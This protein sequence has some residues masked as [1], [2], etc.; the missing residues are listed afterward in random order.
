MTFKYP[1]RMM[2]FLGSFALSLA[3]CLSV[4]AMYIHNKSDMEYA[5]ME[6]VVLVNAN[7]VNNVITKLLYKTQILAALVVQS[8]G[9]INEFERVAATIL[10]DPAI[11]NVLIAPDGIVSAVYPLEG[12]EQVLGLNFFEPGHGNVEAIEARDSGELVLGGPFDLVQGGQALV[13]RLPVY[14]K[15][16]TNTPSFWGV[17]SVTL[18]YPEA[19]SGAGL[20]QLQ[21]QG[22]AFEMWRI[23]PDTNERQIIAASEYAYDHNARYVEKSITILNTTWEFRISPIRNWQQYPETWIFSILGL[24]I[25]GIIACFAVNTYN[26]KM[27]T[28][29]L[30][31][32]TY[33]DSLTGVLNRRGMLAALS[34]LLDT[35]DCKLILCYMDLNKFKFFNDEFG[36]SIGDKVLQTFSET[37]TKHTTKKHL[38]ARM[39]GDEFVLVFKDTDNA[40]EVQ[41][42]FEVV[43]RELGQALVDDCLK[44][45]P[46]TFSVGKAAYPLDCQDLDDLLH[47][48]DSDMYKNKT[49]EV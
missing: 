39:G 44:G 49:V 16:N 8:D 30:E 34:E 11:K 1:K 6:Q 36:H 32:L 18:H 37:L 20:D 9:D 15:N 42:F 5:Q 47:C 21:N 26:L 43:K 33:I 31:T 13:G 23:S 12:N 35:P 2:L 25:S 4:T 3:L 48:A 24:L 41:A 45:I 22:F 27:L 10:D 38:F 19:L 7:K 14:I 28:T 46:I 40:D 29:E 17:V